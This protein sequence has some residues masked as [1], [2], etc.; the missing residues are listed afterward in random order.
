MPATPAIAG[1]TNLSM[2]N[3]RRGVTGST[4]GP[5]SLAIQG[6]GSAAKTS[7]LDFTVSAVGLPS[8]DQNPGIPDFDVPYALS[9]T[10]AGS[11]FASKLGSRSANS[12]WTDTN[13][14]GSVSSNNGDD[15]TYNWNVAPGGTTLRAVW[16]DYFNIAATSY[17]ANRDLSILVGV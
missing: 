2:R 6:R 1:K 16:T 15:C 13:S 14:L 8:G 3:L 9:F 4:S 12:S 17:G 7:M 10:S 11:L 5:F